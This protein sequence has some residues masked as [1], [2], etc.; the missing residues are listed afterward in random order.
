MAR[1]AAATALRA[2]VFPSEGGPTV[3]PTNVVALGDQ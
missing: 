1:T 2:G 3:Q